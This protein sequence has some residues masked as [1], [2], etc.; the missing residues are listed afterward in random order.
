MNNRTRELIAQGYTLVTAGSRLARRIRHAY[1]ADMIENGK[2]AWESPDVLPW[3]AWV[4]RCWES[5]QLARPS[6]LMLINAAQQRCLWQDIIQSSSYSADILQVN[7]IIDQ[8]IQAY[9]LCRSWAIPVFPQAVYLNPDVRAFKTWV[10]IYSVQLD[11]HGWIDT[12]GVIDRLANAPSAVVDTK[13]ALCGFDALTPQQQQLV[14]A[15]RERGHEV[16]TVGPEARNQSVRYVRANDV[17]TEVRS[18]ALWARQVLNR[19]PDAAIGI[20]VPGLQSVRQQV[21]TVF[22]QV[23]HPE[24]LTSAEEIA[25]RHY[26]I[27][28]GR[29][30][31]DYPLVHAAMQVLGL[32]RETQTANQ[33]GV[34]LRSPF[35]RGAGTEAAG[36]AGLDA[37]LRKTGEYE[38]HLANLIRYVESHGGAAGKCPGFINLLKDFT[39]SFRDTPRQQTTRQW[40]ETFSAWLKQFGWPGDRQLTSNEFQV[41]DAWQEALRTLAS[42]G[43]VAGPCRYDAA[44]KFLSDILVRTRFQPESAETPIQISGLP[45]AGAMQFDYLWV[46]GM[47]DQVWPPA[48]EP[49]PFI[50]LSLQ[51]EAGLPGSSAEV[52]RAGSLAIT[53]G[54]TASARELVFSYP[55]L[56][57]DR[58]CRPSPLIPNEFT[59]V[60]ALTIEAAEDYP[61]MILRS[62]DIET[63]IDNTAPPVT[64]ADQASGGSGIFKDQAA[65]AFRSF[66]RHRLYAEGLAGINI[67]LDPAVR[68]QLA[69]RVMQALWQEIKTSENLQ[70]LPEAEWEQMI[71][72]AVD[73]V[74]RRQAHQQPE[75]FTARFTELETRRLTSMAQNWLA[76]E[77]QRPPFTV[78]ALE[79][80]HTVNLD[81]LKVNMRIDRIDEIEDGRL[82]IL[83]YKTGQVSIRGWDGERPDDPQLPLYAV[84]SDGEIVAIA[85]AGLKQGEYG[86]AGLA[87]DDGLLPDVDAAVDKQTKA[88]NWDA[89]L[90]EWKTVLQRLAREFQDGRAIVDPKNTQ[91]CRYCD[92]H[93]LCRIHEL[94][95]TNLVDEYED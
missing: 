59:G 46:T 70:R 21:E 86:F 36:R 49:N 41:L 20:I 80:R 2:T 92:L 18:A 6:G 56:D 57:G 87:A 31:S 38:W 7:P 48:A 67:G 8:A 94:R 35:I 63:V 73:G 85:Y 14:D 29:P 24:R 58:E 44:L 84:S 34:L 54:L 51:R 55:A 4:T 53:A 5:L 88:P 16:V 33:F 89:R 82:I 22:D 74:L 65:C 1:A 26:S 61:E 23:L 47:H 15:L 28:L 32:G 78:K 10:D 60:E 27:A 17:R 12:A 11:K 43:N 9:E 91:T 66:A 75:S 90:E 40:A 52:C 64:A 45:G 71:S 72:G 37:E 62:A 95:T 25:E 42:L 83:D 50:P 3:Q 13:I 19:E 77:R 76:L 79:Q 69:H 68:G 30:L 39:R 93:T 81:G